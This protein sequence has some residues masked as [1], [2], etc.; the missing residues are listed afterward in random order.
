M[1]GEEKI[2]S[3]PRALSLIAHAADGSMRDAL[4]LSDQAIALG[5]GHIDSATVSNIFGYP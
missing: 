3:E 1:L 4:S 2:S 5:N